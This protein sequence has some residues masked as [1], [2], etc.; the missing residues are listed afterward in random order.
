MI[1]KIFKNWS[2]LSIKK[3]EQAPATTLQYNFTDCVKW[4]KQNQCIS[5]FQI[6]RKTKLP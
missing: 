5:N 1:F 6:Q 3:S 4:V 2:A